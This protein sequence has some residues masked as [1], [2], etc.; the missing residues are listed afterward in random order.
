MNKGQPLAY[1][2]FAILATVILYAGSGLLGPAGMLGILLVPLPAA[3]LHL[4][5][6]RI[7][8]GVVVGVSTVVLAIMLSAAA[9][10]Q[11]LLLFGIGSWLLPYLI[12]RGLRWD[13]AWAGTLLAEVLG[14][15]P[16]LTFWALKHGESLTGQVRSYIDQEI[17]KALAFYQQADV[18]AQQV[19]ELRKGGQFLLEV[20]PRL[21]PGLIV[22]S[23]GISLLVLLA[24]LARVTRNQIEIP[25]PSFQQW[26]TPEPLVWVVIAAGFTAF[27]PWQQ[28]QT[29]A[30]NMLVVLLPLYF[31]QGM[32]VVSC[33]LARKGAPGFIK[34]LVYVLLVFINPLP[35]V[36]IGVG[37]F[38]L[39]ADFRKPKIKS[40]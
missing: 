37:L 10:F 12:S 25:G 39:W 32:A 23:L 30:L 18:S 6:G 34:G 31:M 9:A 17:S 22:A 13:L 16:L 40:A 3:Y 5:Y 21:Y 1:L 24:L 15:I 35:M 28:L 8:G 11:Y 29:V 7:S 27:S 14:A 38:D 36:V 2:L 20:V 19:E 26:K 33:F 4:R